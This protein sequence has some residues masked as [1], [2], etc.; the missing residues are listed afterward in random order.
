MKSVENARNRLEQYIANLNAKQFYY[1]SNIHFPPTCDASL[2]TPMPLYNQS[3]NVNQQYGL[4][5]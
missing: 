2:V 5:L 3:K 1:N 4:H